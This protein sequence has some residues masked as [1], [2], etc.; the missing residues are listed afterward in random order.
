MDR[1]DS[2]SLPPPGEPYLSSWSWIFYQTALTIARC[3]R[4]Q[5]PPGLILPTLG[6]HTQSV[7]SQLSTSSWMIS[8][9]RSIFQ[10]E[11]RSRA[12]PAARRCAGPTPPFLASSCDLHTHV[13]KFLPSLSGVP[14]QYLH[15]FVSVSPASTRAGNHRLEEPATRRRLCVCCLIQGP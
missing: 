6:R 9:C 1:P 10:W 7:I 13:A 15:L 5:Q 3:A 8:L 12:A 4:M 2:H 11:Y 14:N